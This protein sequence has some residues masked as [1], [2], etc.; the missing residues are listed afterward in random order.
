MTSPTSNPVPLE[1][2]AAIVSGRREATATVLV[3]DDD[4]DLRALVRDYL[5]A[6]GFDILEAPDGQAMR[7]ELATNAVDIVILDVMMPGEDGLSLAR[8]LADRAELGVIML[9]ALGSENDRVVGLELGADDYLAKPVAPRELLARVRAL[10]RRKA[11]HLGT[12]SPKLA[13]EFAGWQLEPLRRTLRDPGGVVIALSD[14]EFRLLHAFAEQPGKVLS[15][16]L[17]LELARGSE[18]DAFDRAIDTQVSR[19]RRKLLSRAPGEMIRTVRNEGYVF[20]P[21]V[22]RA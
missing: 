1:H 18:S 2:S 19:L 15:R 6:E 5:A 3:V 14:G 9:S 20:L 12:A 16:D 4:T 13:Y 10:L 21:E 7:R 22:R 11:L 17:L 8:S